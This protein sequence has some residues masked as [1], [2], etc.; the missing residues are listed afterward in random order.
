MKNP[1][2]GL[3]ATL[4]RAPI[5]LYKLGLGWVFG[6]RFMLLTHTGRK[7]GL[8]RQAVIEVVHHDPDSDTWYAASGFG[9]KSHWFQNITANPNVTIQIGTRRLP[10]VA[11]RL[12]HPE[13]EAI[14]HRY[15]QTHPTALRELSRIVGLDYDGSEA[16]LRHL[17]EMLPVIAFRSNV[18]DADEHR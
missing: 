10:A 3:Q 16:S 11:E 12:P 13:A 9:E 7:S 14:L 15:A 5:A 2:R 17:A 1:P 8:P 18:Q 4:W 6:Q